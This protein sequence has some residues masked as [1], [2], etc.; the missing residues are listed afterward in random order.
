[1]PAHSTTACASERSPA[2][3]VP[4]SEHRKALARRIDAHRDEG[5]QVVRPTWLEMTTIRCPAATSTA[6]GPM[7]L[8]SP[9]PI[10]P[11]VCGS[12]RR[13]S[14]TPGRSLGV[15]GLSGRWPAC[16]ACRPATASRAPNAG[17]DHLLHRV[18]RWRSTRRP[19]ARHRRASRPAPSSCPSCRPRRSCRCGRAA[20][21][22][23]CPPG[24]GQ[25]PVRAI[26]S[27][28]GSR[29]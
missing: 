11:A 25:C 17:G 13:R 19:A 1:M 14:A 18:Q 29:R 3:Q 21:P 6:V 23:R 4:G 12:G 28:S 9:R 10:G 2:R 8:A 20:P 22:A 7:S 5:R 26:D 27:A 24:V 16:R 15:A